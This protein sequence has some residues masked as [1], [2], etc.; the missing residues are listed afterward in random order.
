MGIT[1]DRQLSIE[2][3]C[4][5]ARLHTAGHCTGKLAARPATQ[6]FR[7][8]AGGSLDAPTATKRRQLYEAC[9]RK[10]MAWARRWGAQVAARDAALAR[11]CW[12]TCNASSR[13]M[14]GRAGGRT[15]ARDGMFP[16]WHHLAW[17]RRVHGAADWEGALRES[18]EYHQ[19]IRFRPAYIPYGAERTIVGGTYSAARQRRYGDPIGAV[20]AVRPPSLPSAVHWPGTSPGARPTSNPRPWEAEQTDARWQSG[21]E[22][23]PCYLGVSGHAVLALHERHSRLPSGCAPARQAADPIVTP[24]IPAPCTICSRSCQKL[25]TDRH[26]RQR[27]EFARRAPWSWEIQTLFCVHPLA[28]EPVDLR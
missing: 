28:A 17:W 22:A 8:T 2:E 3:R 18:R 25:A 10:Q 6:P 14:V 13:A 24:A 20:G 26:L 27:T 5:L 16:I 1:P 19:V 7:Q 23:R 15:M 21:W 11:P 9:T 4:E 12:S